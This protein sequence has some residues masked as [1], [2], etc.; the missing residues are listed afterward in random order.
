MK[1]KLVGK[2]GLST[3]EI[4]IAFA[5]ISIVLVG[6]IGSNFGAQYW[7]IISRTGNEGMYKTKTKLEDIRAIIK[8]DFY[9]ATSSPLTASINPSDPVDESCI[10]GGLCYFVES[11][12]SD[13]SSC[14]KDVEVKVKWQVQKYPTTTNSLFTNLTNSQE[15][16]NLGGD[17]ILNTPLGDWK[18]NNPQI[19]GV[20]KQ[21][22]G[23]R[24]TGIDV[25]HK[26]TY[27][28]AN[29]IPSF[30]ILSTPTAVGVD[31]SVL[32]QFDLKVNNISV[33]ANALDVFEDLS[34]GR[35][36]AFLALATT[37][38][39]LSVL[40]VTDTNNP[41]LK[42]QVTLHNVNPYG[43]FPQGYRLY[44]YGKR[45]Y[46]TVRETAGTEFHIFDISIPTLPTE[47]GNGFE[48]NRTVN[49]LVVRDQYVEGLL[50]RLVFLAS[51][52]NLKELGVLDVTSD[53]ITELNS[54]NLSGIQNGL[55]L[56]L[57]GHKLYF[58][59]SNNTSGPELYVFDVSNPNSGLPITGEAEIAS[60]VTGIKVSGNY[61]LIGTNRSGEEFQIWDSQYENWNETVLNSGRFKS[62]G[63]SNLS[64]LGFDIDGDWIYTITNSGISDMNQ[65]LYVTP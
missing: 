36:Y 24:F 4:M 18:N 2:M 61:V 11:I 40:D 28:T 63:I 55:S 59:R 3:I 39:Q 21:T 47:I 64:P 60:D 32:S 29:T 13:I 42:A 65:I 37:T 50:R 48:L 53:I 52:S 57:M 20:L 25:L 23:K 43:S 6:A 8:Q 1:E 49:D 56:N 7:T 33:S 14:S 34:T 45:L 26:K 22:P 62:F 15:I 27:V 17:C 41:E 12:I 51:D 9:N 19:V 54:V 58:G 35:T 16:I 31:P 30:Y 46:I 10:T 38:N 5:L 44:I